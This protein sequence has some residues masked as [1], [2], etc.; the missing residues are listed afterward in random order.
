MADIT[1]TYAITVCNELKELTALLN[2]L[3]PRI[4]PTDQILIQY[5][6]GNT[7]KE[8][9]DYLNILTSIHQ[10]HKVIGFPLNG[11]F[12]A[13]KNNLKSHSDGIFIFQIDADE[14]PHE[15]L[16]ENIH[17]LISAN[18][19]VDLFL[20]PRINTVE[21]ITKQHVDKWKWRITKMSSQIGEESFDKNSEE[22]LY[23]K[24][25][26]FIIE[27][28]DDVVVYYKPIVNRP[29]YQTR[30]YRRTSEIEWVGKV[31]EQIKGYNTLTILPKEEQYCLYHHKEIKRQEKQN[32]FYAGLWIL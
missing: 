7:P 11:D 10:N 32:E 3:Q 31:H 21:G 2:F 15:F 6:D 9:L 12:A 22:Y 4:K 30:L 8:V 25:L 17:E 26:N 16:V 1:I 27:I 14:T 13:F 5:D 20:I 23:L 28:N 19:D 18:L 29:D 24:Y